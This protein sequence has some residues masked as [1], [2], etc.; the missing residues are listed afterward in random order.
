M[1]YYESDCVSCGFPCMYESCPH[2][3]VEVF[4]CDFCREENVKLY[5]YDNSEICKECL[6]EQFPI[7]DGSDDY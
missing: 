1:R 7:V 6:L 4:V 5:E 2:Y 3:Q